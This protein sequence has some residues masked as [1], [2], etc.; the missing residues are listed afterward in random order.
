MY[1][2]WVRLTLVVITLVIAA[3]SV[4]QVLELERQHRAARQTAREYQTVAWSLSVSLSDLRATQQ[5]YV[6]NGQE[7]DVWLARATAEITG[8]SAG[9]SDLETRSLTVAAVEAIGDARTTLERWHRIDSL[10]REYAADEQT[11][12]ASDLAF[13]DGRDLAARAADHLE[14]TRAVEHEAHTQQSDQRRRAQLGAVFGVVGITLVVALLL[15]PLRPF[16]DSREETVDT[17]S[18]QVP[19]GTVAREPSEPSEL[20]HG[21]SVVS[22]PSSPLTDLDLSEAARVCTDLAQLSD[23][24]GLNDA[25]GR[26]CRLFDARGLVVWVRDANQSRLRPAAAHGYGSGRLDRM[27][28][29]SLDADNVTAHAFRTEQSQTI[30]GGGDLGGGIAVPLLTASATTRCTGVLALELRPRREANEAVEAT[31]SIIAA[32][33][34]TLVSADPQVS[35]AKESIESEADESHRPDQTN[36]EEEEHHPTEGAHAVGS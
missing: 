3:A 34:A 21:V 19:P 14:I 33:L 23:S 8:I 16:G 2:Q 20:T 13:T 25:L 9:L 27:G 28:H 10:A 30:A 6:A 4:V 12:L 15:L 5:A 17:G 32:Q 26:I 1:R 31:A 7:L 24:A 22:A 18:V 29:V 35:A 36:D 11:L